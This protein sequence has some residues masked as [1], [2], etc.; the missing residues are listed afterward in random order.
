MFSKNVFEDKRK[1]CRFI[2]LADCIFK[3]NDEQREMNLIY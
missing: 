1:I 2:F 3:E